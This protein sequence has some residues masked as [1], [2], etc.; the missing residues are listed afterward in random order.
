MR[1]AHRQPDT[2]VG[3]AISTAGGIRMAAVR[4]ARLQ[5]LAGGS[6]LQSIKEH[7]GAFEM[8]TAEKPA[9]R[10]SGNA[11]S[12]YSS[13]SVESAWSVAQTTRAYWTLTTLIQ[14][15]RTGQRTE[16]IR[17]IYAGNSGRAS[18]EISRSFA[19]IAIASKHT[20]KRGGLL[21][22]YNRRIEAAYRQP[23]LFAEPAPKPQQMALV[24]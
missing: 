7:T 19:P 16:N 17:H 2:A 10:L 1:I 13:G 24:P 9:A 3:N 6:A 5:S 8:A 15:R 14:A 21:A 11:S 4:I 23:R 22:S 20:N 18:T 12:N